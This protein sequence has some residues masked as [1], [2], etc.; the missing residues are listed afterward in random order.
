[1][2]YKF[3]DRNAH[4]PDVTLVSAAKLHL[5]D[6]ARRVQLFVPDMAIEI[7]SHNDK[8]EKVMEKA[9]RYRKC[10]MRE[11]WILTLETRRAFLLSDEGEMILTDDRM[12]ESKLIPGFA[13]RLGE[14][15]DRAQD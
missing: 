9:V 4:G 5:L 14:L 7:V 10:G 2:E 8:F 1:Q 11:V 6:G 15:F 13:I 3:G 12:F